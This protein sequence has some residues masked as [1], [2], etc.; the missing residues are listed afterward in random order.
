MSRELYVPEA[1]PEQKEVLIP[2]DHEWGGGDHRIGLDALVEGNK[3]LPS[4]ENPT[5]ICSTCSLT[6]VL[7]YIY[8]YSQSAS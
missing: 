7:C 5:T 2:T 6:S 8:N 3:S 4:D 1:L